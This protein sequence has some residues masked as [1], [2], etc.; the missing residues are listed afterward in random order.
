MQYLKHVIDA[1]T[2]EVLKSVALD[3]V[4]NT[5]DARMTGLI[6]S[7]PPVRRFALR[8]RHYAPVSYILFPAH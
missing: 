7:L 1:I 5:L 3:R 8:P 6:G 2:Y 4:T